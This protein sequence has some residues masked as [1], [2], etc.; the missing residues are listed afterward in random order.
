M[1]RSIR[2]GVADRRLTH[3][4]PHSVTRG[5]FTAMLNCVDPLRQSDV[6]IARTTPPEVKLAQALAAMEDGIRL[7]RAALRHR[8]PAASDEEISNMLADWLA[9]GD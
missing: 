2:A 7:K 1:V 9:S 3:A 5:P 8:H 6:E 4:R